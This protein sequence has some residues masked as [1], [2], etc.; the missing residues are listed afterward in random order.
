MRIITDNVLVIPIYDAPVS[1]MEQPWVHSTEYEQGFVRWQTKKSGWTNTNDVKKK[2]CGVARPY[3]SMTAK[4]AAAP[5]YP[6]RI[7]SLP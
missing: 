1:A 7:P 5:S 4:R 2:A 3:V 6:P